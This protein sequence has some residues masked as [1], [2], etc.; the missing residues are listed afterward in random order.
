M[1]DLTGPDA[2]ALLGN[3]FYIGR[4]ARPCS[5]ASGWLD[6]WRSSPSAYVVAVENTANVVAAVRFARAH[7]LRLVIKGRG[8]SFFGASNAQD[9]PVALD[10]ADGRRH[11]PRRLHA[12][13]LEGGAGNGRLLRR[14]RDVAARLSSGER[15]RWALRPGRRVHYGGRGWSGAGWRIWQFLEGLWERGRKPVGGGARHRRREGTRRQ[16]C[17]GT[18]PVLGAEGRRGRHLRRRHASNVGHP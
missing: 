6:A 11:G 13:W 1:P 8:H 2:K 3:P 10:A 9:S 17:A 7:S 18:R 4:P 12:R 15:W 5:R 14:R 16:P